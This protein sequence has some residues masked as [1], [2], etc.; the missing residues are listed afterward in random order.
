MTAAVAPLRVPGFGHLVLARTIN[1]L[2]FWLG[3][4]ALAVLVF[5][6]TGSALA[7]TGLFLGMQFVPALVAPAVVARLELAGS[8]PALA[9]VYAAEAATF[10]ALAVTADRFVL[11]AVL[12]LA[13][14]DGVLALTARSLTRASAATILAPAGQVRAGNALLNVGFTSAAA[15]GPALGGVIVAGY[16]VGTSL[17]VNAG[18]FLALAVVLA[19]A[20]SLPPAAVAP[21]EVPRRW[22]ARLREGIRYVATRPVL[23]TLTAAQAVAFVFLTAVIPI[24]VVYAK[25]TLDAGNAGFG[26]LLTSWGAGMVVGSLLFAGA[27]RAP[28]WRLLLVGTVALGVAYLALAAAPTLVLACAASALGGIGNGIQW[29]SLVNAVQELTEERFQARV[30]GLVEALGAGMPALGFILGGAVAELLSPRAS[31]LVAGLGVVAVAVAAGTLL[32]RV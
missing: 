7:T 30:V 20:R 22:A 19:T 27:A 15:I 2:G 17:A 5:D 3:T 28:I 18:A 21:E 11:A 12:V 13:A 24:E 14:V 26:A 8:R 10:A 23:R 25:E 1:E 16:G 32:R 29:V 9:A 31:Y 6:E 4:V